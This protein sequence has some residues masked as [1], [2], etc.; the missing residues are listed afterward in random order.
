MIRAKLGRHG[1]AMMWAKPTRHPGEATLQEHMQ[2]GKAS[3]EKNERAR[4]SDKKS[5][6]ES[7]K[8]DIEKI[9]RRIVNELG[10]WSFWINDTIIMQIENI[11]MAID[12]KSFKYAI[13]WRGGSLDGP[14]EGILTTFE[15]ISRELF[16]S[17]QWQKKAMFT[18]K[19]ALIERNERT[20]YSD[21]KNEAKFSKED[22]DKITGRLVNELGEWNFWF[23]DLIIIQKD[24]LIIAIDPKLGHYKINWRG[25]VMAIRGTLTTFESIVKEIFEAIQEQKKAQIPVK[26]AAFSERNEEARYSDGKNQVHISEED[27]IGIAQRIVDELDGWN[28]WNNDTIIIQKGQ[29]I[30]T[31]DPKLGKYTINCKEHCFMAKTAKTLT[32]F[33]SI[34]KEIFQINQ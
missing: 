27:A 18:K 25:M 30:I 9:P 10:A 28:F 8:E 26:K 21:N 17:I 33:E 15:S 34:R 19:E 3:S 12:A 20:R 24:I 7:S 13:H 11:I 23:N 4:N 32:T 14:I 6:R 5:E 22:T 1:F 29:V 2:E 31:I 16:K